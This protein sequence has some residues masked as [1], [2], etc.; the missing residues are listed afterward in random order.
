MGRR[1]RDGNHSPQKNNSI[2]DSVG[3][4]ENGYPVPDSNKTMINVTKLPSDSHI[5]TLKEEILEDIPEKFVEKILDMVNQNVQDSLEK[6][7]DTKNKEQEKRQKQIKELREDLNK[8]QSKIKGTIKR[9]IHE[10]RRTT[11]IIKEELKKDLE[12]LR[13]KN[14]TKILEIKSPFS[15]TKNTVED[16]FS[17]LE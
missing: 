10:L 8:H 1:R 6:F 9:E 14:Q 3:N 11:Q 2:Q 13:R 7:Q 5:K 17:R 12:N 4:E 16:H 15:Q